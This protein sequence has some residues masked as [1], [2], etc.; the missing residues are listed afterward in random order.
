MSA[1]VVN[2]LYGKGRLRLPLLP[3]GGIPFDAPAKSINYGADIL[4]AKIV[5]QTSC[6]KKLWCRHPVCSNCGADILS[7]LFPAISY[8]EQ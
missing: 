4:S 6:L 8:L 2:A 7:A 3:V 1:L 5:V